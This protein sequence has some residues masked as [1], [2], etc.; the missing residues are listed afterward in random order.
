[1]VMSITFV[2]VGSAV[3]GCIFIWNTRKVIRMDRE[4]D[5]WIANYGMV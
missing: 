4:P 5:F 3:L 2:A 1:M